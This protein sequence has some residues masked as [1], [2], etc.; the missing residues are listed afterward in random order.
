[1]PRLEPPTTELT[2]TFWEGTKDDTY[3]VQWCAPCGRPIFY[4]REVCPKCLAPTGLEWR[5]SAGTGTVHAVSVQHRPANP[6]MADRVPYAVALID[7]DAGA[8]DSPN[9]SPNGSDSGRIST[10]RIMS[11]V[12]N[13]DPDSV[14]VGDVVTLAWEPLSDGRKLPVFE[15]T[16]DR[17]VTQ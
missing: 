9:V 8:A 5:R 6:F 7:L 11:N 14:R 3:L 15:P 2:D 17:K 10:V 1:M 16:R 4:P 12:V 13:C